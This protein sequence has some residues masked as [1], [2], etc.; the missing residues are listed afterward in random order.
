MPKQI[1]GYTDP[2]H[3]EVG[4]VGFIAAHK[5]DDEATISL[6]IR[7]EKAEINQINLPLH[8]AQQLALAIIKA[9]P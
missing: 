2:I 9:V 1:F 8:E 3:P 6:Q 4:Y 5:N 7:N